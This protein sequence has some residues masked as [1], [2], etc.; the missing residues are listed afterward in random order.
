MP[1]FSATHTSEPRRIAFITF[2]GVKMLDI[3]GPL[4]VF[5]DANEVL[6]FEAYT[7]TL[8]SLYGGPVETDTGVSLNTRRLAGVG[9][10][11]AGTLIA[12]GGKG[13]HDACRDNRLIGAIRLA[14]QKCGRVAATCTGAFLLGASDLLDGRRCVT[15]WKDCD[16]LAE[17]YPQTQV[18]PD[19]IFIQ[20]RGVWTSAGV[21]AG[22]DLALAMVEQDHS[23]DVAMELARHLLVYVKRPGGQ[24]Q[25]SEAL[26]QQTRTA[27]GR[28]GALHL[29]MKD[30]LVADLRVEELAKR[31][32]MSPRNFARIY[33]DETGQTPA[34]AV[35]M[36]RIE[37]ARIALEDPELTVKQ[38]SVKC[39][40]GSD[41][42]MR[43]SFI[44]QLGVSP[45]AYRN[46]F[47]LSE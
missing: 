15:H 16:R 4:Q 37:A 22:I 33:A 3:T 30:N 18:D 29:W 7:T 42:R 38:V 24:S 35:E 39:G 28:F 26:Q 40:F 45:Q 9:L 12:C 32:G 41:E 14:A 46:S 21:T 47:A 36:M 6:G 34:R 17:A 11:D 19:P 44:R 20:D 10:D 25:F 1:T 27:S 13:V 43:R 2:D 23:R 8:A 31:V 5:A